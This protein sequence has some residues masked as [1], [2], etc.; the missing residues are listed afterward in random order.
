MRSKIMSNRGSDIQILKLIKKYLKKK[1]W[2]VV[3]A[4]LELWNLPAAFKLK[5]HQLFLQ[6][7]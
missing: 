3:L 1:T 5:Y 6:I 4:N 2:F 7:I